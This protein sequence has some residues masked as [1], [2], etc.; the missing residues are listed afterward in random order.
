MEAGCNSGTLHEPTWKRLEC[1]LVLL[2]V[3]RDHRVS[4]GPYQSRSLVTLFVIGENA[5][6]HAGRI[7]CRTVTSVH[8]RR[9][10]STWRIPPSSWFQL[11]N[12]WLA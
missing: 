10:P 7:C 8:A 4:C 3:A 6:R 5:R 12:V 1:Y 2:E 11:A 9:S